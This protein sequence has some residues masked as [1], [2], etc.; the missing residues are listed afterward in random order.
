ML[1]SAQPV[2]E[3]DGLGPVTEFAHQR[4]EFLFAQACRCP[5]HEPMGWRRHREGASCSELSRSRR[6][7]AELS[8]RLHGFG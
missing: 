5:L 7:Y 4:W 1:A 8:R 2:E 6:R 3:S